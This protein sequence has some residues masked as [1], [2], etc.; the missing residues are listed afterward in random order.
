MQ[1]KHSGLLAAL[2]REPDQADVLLKVGLG[3]PLVIVVWDWLAGS[4]LPSLAVAPLTFILVLLYGGVVAYLA[5]RLVEAEKQWQVDAAQQASRLIASRRRFGP[6]GQVYADPPPAPR[7]VAVQAE[8]PSPVAPQPQPAAQQA[9]PPPPPPPPPS[10]PP[11]A[12][13]PPSLEPEPG[14]QQRY[15]L[16]RLEAELQEARREGRQMSLVA[17]DVTIPGQ[18]LTRAA[19]DRVCAEM[20]YIAASH[21]K[22]ISRPVS[23][24]PTEFLYSLPRLDE[25]EAKAFVSKVVQALGDYWCHF[26]IAV[27]PNDATDAESLIERALDACEESRQG[28]EP[29]KQ[30]VRVAV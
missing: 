25:N 30:R 10:P 17:L 15:F 28:K 3:G 18:E 14:F 23:V 29:K 19:V 13:L 5:A 20:A 6:Q 1:E 22:T 11:P 21:P 24:G 27:Y 26:G 16:M 4:V 8:G 7:P 9:A 12:P 2:R